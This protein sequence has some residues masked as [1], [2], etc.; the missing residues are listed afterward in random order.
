MEETQ[1]R[2]DRLAARRAKLIR[3]AI[4]CKALILKVVLM[5]FLL[6]H[7]QTNDTR[8]GT[9]LGKNHIR[10]DSEPLMR[11][12]RTVYAESYTLG[13]DIG[14]ERIHACKDK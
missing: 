1:W 2:K 5:I 12:F 3:D 10:P 8:T 7:L 9:R 6:W 11:A 14:Y 13:E 4:K